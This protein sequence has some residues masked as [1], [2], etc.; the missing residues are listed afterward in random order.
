MPSKALLS[1]VIVLQSPVKGK[2]GKKASKAGPAELQL[3]G[4]LHIMKLLG[5]PPSSAPSD[6]SPVA[7]PRGRRA[8]TGGTAGAEER[9]LQAELVSHVV[10][11]LFE[12]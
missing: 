12:Q 6:A 8:S 4:V 11:G 5:A 2:K 9:P 10:D 1:R 3:A 7:S